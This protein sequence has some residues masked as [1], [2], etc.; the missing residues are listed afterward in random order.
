MLFNPIDKALCKVQWEVDG[1]LQILT[2]AKMIGTPLLFG[3]LSRE[4]AGHHIE[5]SDLQ[6]LLKWA[7]SICRKDQNDACIRH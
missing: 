4:I 1:G 6:P 2:I 5:I 7:R 3:C